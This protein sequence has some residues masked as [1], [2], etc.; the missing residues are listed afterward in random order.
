VPQK[1]SVTNMPA[2]LRAAVPASD[3]PSAPGAPLISRTATLDDPFT[4]SLLAEIAR[5]SRTV[6][7]SPEQIAEAMDAG[8]DDN[9]PDD[10]P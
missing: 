9:D 1:L 2:V 8:P 6:D 3:P 5:R 10:S 7:V 4:T